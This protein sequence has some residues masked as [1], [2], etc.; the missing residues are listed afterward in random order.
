MATRTWIRDS[1]AAPAFGRRSAAVAPMPAAFG[2]AGDDSRREQR[3]RHEARAREE[4]ERRAVS[5][6]EAKHW[7]AVRDFSSEKEYPTLGG[8][9]APAPAKKA[10]TVWTTGPDETA[11]PAPPKPL[12]TVGRILMA[13]ETAAA[14]RR[15]PITNRCYDDGPEDYDGP[16]EE[17]E[18]SEFNPDLSHGRRGGW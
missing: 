16:E 9:G 14:Q 7:A 8:G 12:S 1:A 3:A 15:P 17:E 13:R 2:G 10:P 5:A 4:A 18:D 11:R 6:A